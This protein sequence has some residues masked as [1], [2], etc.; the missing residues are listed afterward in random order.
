MTVMS[1]HAT[2]LVRADHD[3]YGQARPARVEGWRNIEFQNIQIKISMCKLSRL[4]VRFCRRPSTTFCINFI[5]G[6]QSK[7]LNG[8]IQLQLSF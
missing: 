4:M 8:K 1:D 2:M 6:S 3:D 7:S 5:A